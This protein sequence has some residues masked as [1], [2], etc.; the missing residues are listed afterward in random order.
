[1]ENQ[2]IME[3]KLKRID[4]LDIQVA[5][6]GLIWSMKHEMKDERT[7]DYRKNVVLPQSIQKWETLK[8]ECVR[9]FEEQDG[10]TE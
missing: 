8:A 6:T 1:M 9:Q 7:D 10:A 4:M 2:E 5:I 3:L